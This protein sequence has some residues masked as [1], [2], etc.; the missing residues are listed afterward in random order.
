[1]HKVMHIIGKAL[2]RALSAM[3]SQL[4]AESN[5]SK[6]PLSSTSQAP[7]VT[8]CTIPSEVP[9][10]LPDWK[11]LIARDAELWYGKRADSV[12]GKK[13]LIASSTG[14]QSVGTA[15]DSLVAAALT[16]RGC[17]VHILLCDGQLSACLQVSHSDFPDPNEFLESGPKRHCGYCI[18]N[19]AE[20]FEP[21]GLRIHKFS[22]SI[23]SEDRNI[24]KNLAHLVPYADIPCFTLDDIPV[25]FHAKEA[26]LR[27]LSIGN[28]D[29]DPDSE[30]VLRRYFEGAILS[31]RMTANLLSANEYDC[32]EIYHGQYVPHGPILAVARQ[33]GRHAAIWG[34]AYKAQAVMFD[35]DQIE[36]LI[37]INERGWDD[38]DF[39]EDSER[40]LLDYLHHRAT[41]SKDW[42]WDSLHKDAE[43]DLD[44]L[45][46]ELG[47]DVTKPTIGLLTNVVWDADCSYKVNA[48]PSQVDWVIQTIEYFSKRPELQ[49]LIRIHPAEKKF[50]VS[51]QLMMDEIMHRF[52]VIPNNVYIVPP[53]RAANTYVLMNACESVIIFGTTMG[54]E[55]SCLGI[56][57]I[58][59]GQ[60]AVRNK[61]ISHDPH[62]ESEYFAL[63]DQLPF[64]NRRMDAPAVRRAR[65]LAYH[66]FFRRGI[67]LSSTVPRSG[68][69][70]V[71]LKVESL[72]DLLPGKDPG[73][74]TV[75][76]GIINS[77]PFV[78]PAERFA[79]MHSG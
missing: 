25:G 16:L 22:E 11:D 50:L 12:S 44:I 53:E 69:P 59:A 78:F 30:T 67:P 66:Y 6:E 48:F 29:V 19:G 1:M 21:L 43:N 41:G 17:D 79:S 18:K 38:F 7:A 68:W 32:I 4:R 63:L 62:N 28:L 49:L 45:N 75:C 5:S 76:D 10:W 27:Y 23:T 52:P 55:L 77:A 2:S 74:D 35:H 13:V 56:P 24:A 65:M 42:L 26:T 70:C 33:Q 72:Q 14:G 71:S 40:Q 3:S 58:C 20:T 51:R 64:S 57:I 15:I 60:A 73:L 8:T 37:L 46:K 9:N 39:T 36:G 31:A 47:I 61:G 54:M 34:V